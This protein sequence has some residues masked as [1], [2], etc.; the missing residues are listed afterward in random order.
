MLLRQLV[1]QSSKHESMVKMY[2]EPVSLEN[3]ER[4]M[5]EQMRLAKIKEVKQQ[6]DAILQSVKSVILNQDSNY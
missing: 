4:K 5:I 3:I 2:P 1:T 6:K